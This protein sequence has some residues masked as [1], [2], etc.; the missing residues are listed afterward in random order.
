MAS[1]PYRTGS[2]RSGDAATAA[3]RPGTQLQIPLMYAFREA[4]AAKDARTPS[5]D[6]RDGERVLSERGALRRRGANEAQ[7]RRNLEI[8]LVQLA[9][10][11]NLE[12]CEDLDDYEYVRRSVLNYG[13]IDL[14]DM[15]SEDL[16]LRELSRRLARALVAHEP[17]FVEATLSVKMRREFDEVH[18]K[19]AFDV[20]AEMACKPVDIPMEFVAEID[21]GSGKL[22]FTNLSATP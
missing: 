20:H 10:T 1:T 18:Q 11:I 9:N 5:N 6:Y 12:A 17:R 15:T 14:S 22:N 2:G 19:I 21:V 13:L 4:A 16:R 7:L 3:Q 8:D